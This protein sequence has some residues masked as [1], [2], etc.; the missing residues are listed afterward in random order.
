MHSSQHGGISGLRTS[1]HLLHL[2]SLSHQHPDVYYLYIDV[3]KAFNSI[4]AEFLFQLL[5]H[6]NLPSEVISSI[7]TLYTYTT[8][9]PSVDGRVHRSHKQHSGLRQGCHLSPRLFNLYLNKI[10][11][12]ITSTVQVDESF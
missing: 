6:Y 7:R 5:S 1:D 9:Q 4:P 10:L 11:H 2:K 12:H 8:E 3:E